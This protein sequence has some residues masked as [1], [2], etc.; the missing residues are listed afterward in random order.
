MTHDI[1]PTHLVVKAMRDNGYKNASYALAELMDN[2][3]QADATRVELLC[4]QREYKGDYRVTMR[5]HQIAV[6]DNGKGMDADTLRIALQFGN[7]RYLEAENHTGIGRFGMGLPSSSISQCTKVD[8]WSWQNGVDSALHTYLDLKKIESGELAEVPE[9]LPLAIPE[10][11]RRVG[12][13]F[14]KSGTLVMWSDLDRIMFKTANAIIDNSEFLIGRL[15][16]SF[17]NSGKLQIRMVAF[18]MDIPNQLEEK[19]ALPNDPGYLMERTSCPTPWDKTSMFSPWGGQYFEVIHVIR[20][21]DQDHEVKVRF[22]LAKEQARPGRNPGA[23]PHGKHAAKNVGLSI[24]RADRELDLDRGWSSPSD[25]RDRWWGVEIDFPPGLDDLFGVTNN[26]QSAR[27]FSEMAKLDVEMLLDGKSMEEVRAE[28]E[29]DDDPRG[30]LLDIVNRIQTSINTMRRVLRAQKA[31]GDDDDDGKRHNPNSTEAI[32]TEATNERKEEGHA[33]K[34]DEQESQS[35]QERERDIQQVLVDQGV[36]EQ[37]AEML[38]A[39]TVSSGL[40]YLFSKSDIETPAFFS[41]TLKG[42]AIIITLNT[43]HPAYSRLVEILQEDVEG[44]DEETLKERLAKARDGLELLLMAWARY[45]DEQPDGRL[46]EAA[47]KARWEWGQIAQRFL[48]SED[49]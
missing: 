17:L 44:E 43:N 1:V 23:L 45:E 14:E 24:V 29:E 39:T 9:P 41:V 40:K 4:G 28:L 46:R 12:S 31:S 30:P 49:A 11:W 38:A 32:A 15:Y 3:I 16:R 7:G 36:A 26:K 27:N 20:F 33:G 21:R 35:P 47:K 2:S 5:I 22:S 48:E 34:T 42:G 37:K 18:N 19:Y 6:L 25:A 10:I 13:L 8:V